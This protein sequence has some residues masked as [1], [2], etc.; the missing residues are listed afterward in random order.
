VEPTVL[1]L[2]TLVESQK[3]RI[4]A[5]ECALLNITGFKRQ[6]DDGSQQGRIVFDT[7]TTVP[8]TPKDS[9]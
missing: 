1:D 9:A 4:D 5:L 3:L 6:T 7:S 2:I 8:A